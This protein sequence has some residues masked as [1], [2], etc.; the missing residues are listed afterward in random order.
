MSGD[1]LL[2]GGTGQV[3]LALRRLPWPD[4]A[5][6]HAPTRAELDLADGASLE[7]ALRARP[8]AAVISSGAFTA[9]DRA[10]EEV[11]DAWRVNALAPAILAAGCRRAGVPIVHLST[12]YVFGGD[13]DRPYRETDP[14]GPMGVYG[15]S[16]EG[17]EGA[18]RTG[19]GRH[20]ILRTAWV[21]GPDG[22]NFLRTM[23]RLA[24][25]RDEVAIVSDQRGCPTSASDLAG[26]VRTV[27]LRMLADPAAPTGTFHVANGG[28]AT[29]DEVA[30][31]IFAGSARR[32]GASARVRPIASADYPT[33][34]RRPRESRLATDKVAAAY[35]IRLRPW[36]E[37]LDEMLDGLLR[38][39]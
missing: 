8:W 10:E 1:V 31:A 14:V 34:A 33:A 21:M 12:D 5:V 29:W 2:T 27:L 16:K 4:G 22:R 9:V 6:L 13:G 7:R 37:A 38:P 3:G 25:E 35:G 20:A 11:A 32:G 39:A 30:S 17:G 28:E 26:A 18:V 24:G 19:T 23:L 36:R 15:A